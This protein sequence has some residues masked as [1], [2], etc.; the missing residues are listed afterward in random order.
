MKK[1]ARP[2]ADAGHIVPDLLAPDLKL[3]MCGTA[4]GRVSAREKAYYANPGNQFWQAVHRIGL[5]PRRLHPKEYPG[6]LEL[7]IGLTDLC[8]T[9]FGNDDELPDGAFDRDALIRKIEQ[10]QPSVLA[11]TSKTGGQFFL[12]RKLEYGLQEDR[13]GDTTI[14]VCCSPSGRARRFW[15]ENVWEGLAALVNEAEPKTS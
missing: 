13:I 6:M 7:G 1:D 5:T 2:A 12:G 10:F 15:Q 3:V 4:L 8:K 9:A 11:F 14:Y